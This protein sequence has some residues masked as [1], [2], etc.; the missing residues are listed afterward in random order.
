MK[1]RGIAILLTA[2]LLLALLPGTPKAIQ[3]A[4]K[5]MT[6]SGVLRYTE[7]GPGAGIDGLAT[8]FL[9]G[10]AG[11][12]VAAARMKSALGLLSLGDDPS[13]K[14]INNYL[15]GT[16][17]V[18]LAGLLPV[19][20]YYEAR[21]EFILEQSEGD[22]FTLRE[23]S[24]KW[25]VSNSA[26]ISG[27]GTFITDKFAGSGSSTLDPEKD[28]IELSFDFSKKKVMYTL[29][30]N[31]SHPQ[32][33][34]GES[35]W[36]AADGA[37]V[38]YLRSQEGVQTMGGHV[39]DQEIPEEVVQEHAPK[40]GFYYTHRGPLSELKYT[41]TYRNL[42]DAQVL[43]D[44]QIYDE[45]SAQVIEPGPNEKVTLPTCTG[46]N[47]DSEFEAEAVPEAYGGMLEWK[48]PEFGGEQ[49][50]YDPEDKLGIKMHV[51][52]DNDAP[53]DNSAYGPYEITLTFKG[54][55]SSCKDPEPRQAR[56][57]YPRGNYNNPGRKDPN[58]FYY[59]MQTKAA[60]GHKGAVIYDDATPYYGYFDGYADPAKADRIY[61][62][63]I[64]RAG[65]PSSNPYTGKVTEGIDL[66][67][68]TIRH[69]WTHLENYKDWWGKKGYQTAQDRDEDHVPD[70]REASYGMDP[71]NRDT[72][73][74]GMRD[75]EIP[76]YLQEDTWPNGSAN[77][78]DWADP[79]K[80]T[81]S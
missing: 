53:A 64:F 45:C 51:W 72:F 29:T 63:D 50:H 5:P 8:S 44:Y 76:A 32:P 31:I 7:N 52:Y 10:G 75:S 36:S 69:E 43:A 74:M 28:S 48:L 33:T 55:S 77:K 37:I 9:V 61:V 3:A 47:L 59:W 6:F 17:P 2:A 60:Q 40:R 78:E 22:T 12:A 58:W 46:C 27:E 14:T 35:T 66:F 70:D 67:A 81:G 68:A 65:N 21:V 62:G 79:G 11:G 41:E 54:A 13:I 71:H 26:E 25:N 56:I 57:F 42:L 18:D 16:V 15:N 49:P 20:A 30:V 19:S 34:S 4:K 38:F 23:G 1:H 24:V 80:Q 73:G 39:L